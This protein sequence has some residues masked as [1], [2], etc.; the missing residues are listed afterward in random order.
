MKELDAAGKTVAFKDIREEG[1]DEN[2][3]SQLVA[4]HGRAKILNTR[5]TTWRNLDSSL[6]DPKEDSDVVGL[7]LDNP[8]LIKRPILFSDQKSYVG[9]G[10]NEQS[11]LLG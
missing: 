1:L 11:I 8:T 4:E 10:K 7:L 3:L 9:W 6:K 2:A 5:S